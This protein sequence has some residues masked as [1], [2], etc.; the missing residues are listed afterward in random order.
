MKRM[1]PKP[2]TP[3]LLRALPGVPGAVPAL[4]RGGVGNNPSVAR[5]V[6]PKADDGRGGIGGEV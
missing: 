1:N 4:L 3:G 5:R 2:P 6:A